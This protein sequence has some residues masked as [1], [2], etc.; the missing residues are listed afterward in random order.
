MSHNLLRVLFLPRRCRKL[1]WTLT[2]SSNEATALYES[3]ASLWMRLSEGSATAARLVQ[4]GSLILDAFVVAWVR[5]GA[6]RQAP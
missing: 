4:R 6:A 2:S 5:R 3:E 1:A